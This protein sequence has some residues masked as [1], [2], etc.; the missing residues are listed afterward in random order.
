MNFSNR[1]TGCDPRP[2]LSCAAFCPLPKTYR[3]VL[4]LRKVDELSVASTAA[5]LGISEGLVKTRLLRARLMM[6]KI[7]VQQHRTAPC[8]GFERKGSRAACKFPD[9]RKFDRRREHPRNP[10]VPIEG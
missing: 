9:S 2:A 8:V 1:P 4:L 6:Q 3:E 5:L 10:A 7:L